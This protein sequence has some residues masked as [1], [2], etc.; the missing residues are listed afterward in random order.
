MA[1]TNFKGVPEMSKIH[2][3]TM[4][5]EGSEEEFMSGVHSLTLC[6][7]NLGFKIKYWWSYSY[8]LI[9]LGLVHIKYTWCTLHFNDNSINVSYRVT[10]FVAEG[11]IWESILDCIRIKDYTHHI[12]SGPQTSGALLEIMSSRFCSAWWSLT[13]FIICDSPEQ[14]L[15]SWGLC[16]VNCYCCSSPATNEQPKI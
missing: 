1:V 4:M 5:T 11:W 12:R 13:F 10:M 6:V 3:N 7:Q 9:T 16:G 14:C 15:G 2:N 8:L